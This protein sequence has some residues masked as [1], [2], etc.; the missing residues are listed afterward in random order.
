THYYPAFPYASYAKMRIEDVLDLRAFM[1]TLPA[2][3]SQ[4]AGHELGFPYSVRRAVGLWKRLYVSPD[5]VIELAGASDLVRRGQYLVEGPGHC[6]ECHTVRDALGGWKAPLWLAG[7]RNPEGEGRIPNITPH[8]DGIADWSEG[9]IA[10]ALRSGLTP[11]FDQ[12]EGR[13]AAVQEELSHLPEDDLQ[14]I[15]AYLKAVPPLPDAVPR[16]NTDE[17][18]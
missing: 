10:E 11:D 5:P 3:A 13:M 15:A 12:F 4:V 1:E 16:A 7:A 2:V 18:R 8:E 6:G 14:A 17:R 9:D